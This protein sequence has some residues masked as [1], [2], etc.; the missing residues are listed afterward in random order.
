MRLVDIR[1]I[2]NGNLS[3]LYRKRVMLK[4]LINDR[5]ISWLVIQNLPPQV[6]R[7]ANN[8]ETAYH[9]QAN[10]GTGR[11]VGAPKQ[12]VLAQRQY[13]QRQRKGIGHPSTTDSVGRALQWQVRMNQQNGKSPRMSISPAQ[14]RISISPEKP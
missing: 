14:T 4:L 6:L 7:G 10:E 5:S 3:H 2:Y 11:M 9:L 8:P 12:K 1:E 13:S